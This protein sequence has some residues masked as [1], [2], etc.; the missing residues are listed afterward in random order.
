M[1]K[2]KGKGVC[3]APCVRSCV[4]IYHPHPAGSCAFFAHFII[5]YDCASIIFWHG[6]TGNGNGNGKRKRKR[7]EKENETER[8][9]LPFQDLFFGRK[10]EIKR[11]TEAEAK[12]CRNKPNGSQEAAFYSVNLICTWE[13][14][15]CCVLYRVC[16]WKS[17]ISSCPIS[18]LFLLPLTL[19]G[20]SSVAHWCFFLTFLPEISSY[21]VFISFPEFQFVSH[22]YVVC[23][24]RLKCWNENLPSTISFLRHCF[25][26]KTC[27]DMA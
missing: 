15:V 9:R 3:M 23:I 24:S 6:G 14:H 26:F 25:S 5:F 1:S 20:S 11:R 16:A 18:G 7:N 10:E 13:S 27:L 8:H 2:G 19:V 17:A 4:A 12:T 21:V 22:F